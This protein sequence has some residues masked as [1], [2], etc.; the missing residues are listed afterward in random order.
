MPD[1][2]S[3]PDTAPKLIL[4]KAHVCC[5][6]VNPSL[7][8]TRGLT[9]IATSVSSSAKALPTYAMALLFYSVPKFG[10]TLVDL[11][12]SHLLPV[13]TPSMMWSVPGPLGVQAKATIG[14]AHL[15]YSAM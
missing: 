1:C 11:P 15:Q 10:S 5:A 14:F 7:I 9:Q 12:L 6:S 3:G 2:C 8:H 4:L 13:L